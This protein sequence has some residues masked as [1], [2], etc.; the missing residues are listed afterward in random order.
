[1]DAITDSFQILSLPSP[2]DTFNRSN[3]GCFSVPFPMESFHHDRC[4]THGV[5]QPAMWI[6]TSATTES[7]SSSLMVTQLARAGGRCGHTL[8]FDRQPRSRT[9]GQD[10]DRRRAVPLP[11]PPLHRRHNRGRK[12]PRSTPNHGCLV[13]SRW[14]VSCATVFRPPDRKTVTAVPSRGGVWQLQW[15]WRPFSIPTARGGE[16][17]LPVSPWVCGHGV[18]GRWRHTRMAESEWEGVGGW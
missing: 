7:A 2:D 16:P 14:G 6:G 10:A 5:G 4:P 13:A 18:C 15:L 17:L 11:P 12:R 8:P 1:M 3:L 9:R